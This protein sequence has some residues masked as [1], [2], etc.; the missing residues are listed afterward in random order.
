MEAT[1]V[2]RWLMYAGVGLVVIGGVV[3]VLG[4]I[5]DLGQLPGDTS[6]E[7]ENIRIYAPLTTMIIVSIVLTILLNLILRWL[8]G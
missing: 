8:R 3:F 7:G 2:G 5:V 1:D 6:Y 4:R